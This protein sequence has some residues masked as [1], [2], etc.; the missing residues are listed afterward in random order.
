MRGFYF[1]YWCAEISKL[2]IFRVPFKSNEWI[3][4]C[5]CGKLFGWAYQGSVTSRGKHFSWKIHTVK[6]R[7]NERKQ[8][9]SW[10]KSG[11][12][13]TLLTSRL[14][15]CFSSFILNYLYRSPSNLLVYIDRWKPKSP[16][17]IFFLAQV[18]L[19]AKVTALPDVTAWN[20]W[21][22]GSCMLDQW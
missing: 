21:L 9:K 18:P 20:P 17:T 4:K 15:T 8:L 10:S 11:F 12:F 19:C 3:R 6:R 5:S 16:I 14:A 13:V 2:F 1:R 22:L 7:V